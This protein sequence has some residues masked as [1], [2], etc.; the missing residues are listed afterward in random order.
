MHTSV[1]KKKSSKEYVLEFPG[2][3]KIDLGNREIQAD[4]VKW[5]FA[6]YTSAGGL[7]FTKNVRLVALKGRK[8]VL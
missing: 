8:E 1:Y 2:L 7:M 6:A 4:I 3:T 5:G